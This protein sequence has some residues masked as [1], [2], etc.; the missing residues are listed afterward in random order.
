MSSEGKVT[1]RRLLKPWMTIL[2]GSFEAQPL[3]VLLF[4]GVFFV[5]DSSLKMQQH[6]WSKCVFMSWWVQ[7]ETGSC[8]E[9]NDSSW[10]LETSCAHYI[11]VLPRLEHFA[12]QSNS[13]VHRW[14]NSVVHREKNSR[15]PQRTQSSHKFADET[16]SSAR[17]RWEEL[18]YNVKKG[19][20]AEP[21]SLFFTLPVNV[22]TWMRLQKDGGNKL[23]ILMP[24]CCEKN[25]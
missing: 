20:S 6:R 21:S 4:W 12:L 25:I 23:N 24:T 13:E 16:F 18:R 14:T 17:R 2:K 10:V 1:K 19:I 3:L 5:S 8:V 15:V 22:C 7:P 11:G 9:I